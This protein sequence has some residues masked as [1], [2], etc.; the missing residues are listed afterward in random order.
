MVSVD[1]DY[2]FFDFSDDYLDNLSF[3]S[4]VCLK[5]L[6]Y[7]YRARH[8]VGRNFYDEVLSDRS[9]CLLRSYSHRYFLSDLLADD[10]VF[11]SRDDLTRSY[12]ELKRVFAFGR[13][14]YLSVDKLSS[15][16]HLYRVSF[17]YHMKYLFFNYIYK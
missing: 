11:E 9:I 12:F 13:I 2:I 5:Q 16:V 4:S 14:E 6:S 3:F 10:G 17:C 8:L 15:I 1:H 7:F